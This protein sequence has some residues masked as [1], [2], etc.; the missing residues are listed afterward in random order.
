MAS[1]FKNLLRNT[2]FVLLWCAY[3]IS[4]MGDHLSELAVL[5][6]QN[7]LDENTDIT[8]LTARITFALMLPF[9][10]FGPF[11]GTLADR[12]PRRSLMI[13]ADLARAAILISLYSLI[14]VSTHRYGTTWGPFIPILAV[15]FFAAMFGPAR[16]AMVPML[17]KQDELV[18]ANA[19]ITGL[20]L[21]GTI[22][23]Q[24]ISGIL[25]D[26]NLI[27]EAFYLD[28]ATFCLSAFCIYL[29][30]PKRG[31]IHTHKHQGNES[32]ITSLYQGLIYLRGHKHIV[33][34]IG[35]AVVTWT[36]GSAV[37]SL[38]PAIV[39]NTYQGEFSQIGFYLGILGLGFVTGS[40]ILFLLGNALRGEI[41]LTH[42]LLGTAA[43]L[44]LLAATIFIPMHVTLAKTI[45]AISL[46]HAGLFAV[47]IMVSYN[48]MLQRFV[49][50]QYRGR[51]Y[52]VLNLATIGGLLL[53][54]GTL[55]IPK[56]ANLD[57]WSGYVLLLSASLLAATGILTLTIRYRKPPYPTR[58]AFYRNINEF[59]MKFWY[60]LHQASRCTIPHK[61]PTI[62]TA[63]HV[64]PIDPLFVH[65]TCRY[66][67]PAFMIAA[68]YYNV[69]GISHFIK[70][71]ECIPVRRG[72]NDIAAI[73]DAMRRLRDGKLVGIFIQGGIRNRGDDDDLKNGVA[74][75]ALRTG[76]TVVPAHI[77]G[78]RYDESMLKCFLQRQNARI[79]YGK[80]VDLSEFTD[81]KPE[82]LEAASQKIYEAIQGLAP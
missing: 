16:Q 46:F 55:A 9:F 32:I 80:P 30:S 6:T 62:I 70:T 10:L 67:L 73:K 7:A 2:N 59:L 8:P 82:T 54:T 65:A 25:A 63:N 4:A 3:G 69:P 22:A 52:G 28:A 12:I 81:R 36:T 38:I 49:P 42:A 17:V 75:M 5:A 61:G 18:P 66:R 20:G 58:Y 29:I 77:S 56:W 57:Q 79:A 68:E 19:T 72:E 48:A 31:H 74:M 78:V 35:I 27:R 41:A 51:V 13:T 53:A 44:I 50:N 23:A 64:S 24:V 45:G 39:K 37:K 76:A 47:S 11:M 26:H 21:I 1:Q 33:Q 34:L 14:E 15:G 40:L 60:R 43:S 71:A